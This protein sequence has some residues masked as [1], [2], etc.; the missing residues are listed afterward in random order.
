[1]YKEIKSY[2]ISHYGGG[3]RVIKP[4]SYRAIIGLWGDAGLSAALYFH[5]DPKSMPDGDSLPDVGQS[6]SHYPIADLFRILDI[7]RNE[8]PVYYEQLS[9]W[10]N[11]ASIRT[12][13]EPTGE[14]EPA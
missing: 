1:M 5:D 13:L 11:M 8:R 10:P 2:S 7:L 3:K 6:M 4:Y 12:H 9:N 14:G